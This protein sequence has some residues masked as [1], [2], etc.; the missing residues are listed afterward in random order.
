MGIDFGNALI[1]E[2]ASLFAE[3]L[4]RQPFSFRHDLARDSLFDDAGIVRLWH[5]AEARGGGHR[6][7]VVA[8]RADGVEPVPL[9]ATGPGSLIGRGRTMRIAYLQDHDAGCADLLRRIVAEA[10]ALAGGSLAGEIG[11]PSL[12][13]LVSAPG[14]LTNFHMDHQSN[15][16]FQLRGRK[17]VSLFDAADREVLEEAAIERYYNGTVFAARYRESFQRKAAAYVLMPGDGL[18]NPPLGPHWV[19]NGEEVSVSLSVNFS[20]RH[21]EARARVYQVN[22][23]LRRLGLAPTPPGRLALTDR[24]KQAP[25]RLLSRQRPQSVAEL[26]RSGP[27]GWLAPLRALRGRRSG[28]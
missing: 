9:A 15:L 25:F 24:L 14:A 28:S 6:P 11:F 3:R 27:A 1:Q 20:L 2:G 18:H 4:N 23:L 7:V 10:D 16:L 5:Q 13:L 26:V 22:G 19:R 17:L 21:T 12:T 8:G